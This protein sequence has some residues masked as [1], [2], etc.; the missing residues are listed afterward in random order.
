MAAGHKYL[1][2]KA[3]EPWVEEMTVPTAL[4]GYGAGAGDTNN[5]GI[6]EGSKET[7]HPS[8]SWDCVIVNKCDQASTSCL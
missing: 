1:L 4:G 8:T 5:R 2:V 6:P 7:F 3:A